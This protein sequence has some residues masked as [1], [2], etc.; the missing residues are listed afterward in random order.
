[1]ETRWDV[2]GLGYHCEHEAQRTPWLVN[3]TLWHEDITCDTG[4][5]RFYETALRHNSRAPL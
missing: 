2:G 1:M 3:A 5:E 4:L